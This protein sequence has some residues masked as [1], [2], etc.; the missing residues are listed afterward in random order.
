M[1]QRAKITV[2]EKELIATNFLF[3]FLQ[4]YETGHPVLFFK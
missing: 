1:F 2:S 4:L 3:L